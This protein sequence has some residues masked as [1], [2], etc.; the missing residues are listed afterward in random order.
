MIIDRCQLFFCAEIL[1]VSSRDY[2]WLPQIPF[3]GSFL[4]TDKNKLLYNLMSM[5]IIVPFL[6]H[7]S[8]VSSRLR[9]S[10]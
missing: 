2:A 8:V 5:S 4:S 10:F 6:S 1:V 9:R 3:Q 7:C